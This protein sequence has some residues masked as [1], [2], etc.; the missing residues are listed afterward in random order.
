MSIAHDALA[1][2]AAGRAE[3]AIARLEDDGSAAARL[4]LG[5]WRIEGRHLPR[6]LGLARADFAA[7][8]DFGDA[9]AARVLSA[10]LA[11]GAG[12]TRDWPA[13]LALLDTWAD[14]DPIAARQHN[15]IAAMD[16]DGAGD[17]HSLPD[18]RQLSDT[19]DVRTVPALFT[20]A[21][22]GFLADTAAPRLKPARIFHEGRGEWIA[23][24]IRQSRAAGFPLVAEWPAVHALNRRLAAATGTATEQGEPL[25]VLRYVPGDRYAPH[26]DAVPGLANQRVLTALVYLNDDYAGGETRFPRAGLTFRGQPGDALIFANTTPGGAPDQASEHEGCPVTTGTKLLASRWIRA[27]PPGP[28]GFGPDEA[29]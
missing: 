3:E 6:D 21:E 10:L 17:P 11:T 4:T 19:P 18:A 1:L 14:R 26:L 20:P 28:D 16:L 25:Q 13:A 22:C 24:P 8:A 15:L 7:A 29:R 12:G 9:G 5:L 23:D 2:A 27:R